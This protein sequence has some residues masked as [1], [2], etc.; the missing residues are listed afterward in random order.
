[1]KKYL[2]EL[3]GTF[4]LVFCGTGAIIIN[5]QTGGALSHAGVSLTW[6]LAVTA[7]I[8]SIG[9]ISGCHIN[10]AVSIAFTLAGR[11]SPKLLPGYIV[12]Q[13]AGALMASLTLKLLFPAN[14]LLGASLPAGS[15]AQS[16]ILEFLLTFFLMF[17][18]MIVAHGSKERG[19]FAGIAIGTVVGLEALFAGP[20]CGASMN[21]ARSLAPAIISGHTGSLW[22]Y[23]LA[24]VLGAALAMPVWKYLVEKR[25]R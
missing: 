8:Y 16:F 4:L 24:P 15:A 21:P 7:L 6:G 25:D 17:V 14:A 18:I 19:R 11:F 3:T 2:A 13:F 5:Q 20:I 12:S 23:L 1:M 10:P 9:P 22:I